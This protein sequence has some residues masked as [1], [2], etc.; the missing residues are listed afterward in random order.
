MHGLSNA[1]PVHPYSVPPCLPTKTET[2][3]QAHCAKVSFLKHFP[4]IPLPRGFE[5]LSYSSVPYSANEASMLDLN[6]NS[7]Q[8]QPAQDRAF[9]PNC[10]S[11]A[12]P[13]PQHKPPYTFYLFGLKGCHCLS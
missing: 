13:Q 10:R 12:A 4:F 2:D 1:V 8:L 11:A 6:A 9:L 7:G 5:T 3:R